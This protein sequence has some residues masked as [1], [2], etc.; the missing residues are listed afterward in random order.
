MIRS[1]AVTA[2]TRFSRENCR[3]CDENMDLK[4][5]RDAPYL[6]G[7]VTWDGAYWGI[8][9]AHPILNWMGLGA[10]FRPVSQ[11]LTF[12]L[13]FSHGS[14]SEGFNEQSESEELFLVLGC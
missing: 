1:D 2:V 5:G 12:T 7:S 14:I 4:P 11:P 3:E 6:F 13:I 10:V 8:T 9:A